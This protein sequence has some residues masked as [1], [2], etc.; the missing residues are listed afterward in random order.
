MAIFIK[1]KLIARD[2]VARYIE[3]LAA[4]SS[5]KS[6]VSSRFDID[7]PVAKIDRVTAQIQL[8]RTV[9]RDGFDRLYSVLRRATFGNDYYTY[10]STFTVDVYDLKVLL[11]ICAL[12][13]P[14]FTNYLHNCT[15]DSG[16]AGL[17][18]EIKVTD[19]LKFIGRRNDP[20]NRERLFTSLDR[21]CRVAVNAIIY[22]PTTA[23]L[24]SSQINCHENISGGLIKLFDR[25][26][27]TWFSIGL[28][29]TLAREA[30]VENDN[31]KYA[32]IAMRE[33]HALS[34]NDI[35]MILLV[36]FR[37]DLGAG[38]GAK[39]RYDDVVRLVRGEDGNLPRVYPRQ[40]VR[41]SRNQHNSGADRQSISNIK[42]A[43][44]IIDER[45]DMQ[46]YKHRDIS[47]FV[48]VRPATSASAV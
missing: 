3:D 41:N 20:E 39:Y 9:K 11:A 44:Q 32:P 21:L 12:G 31:P 42:I 28:L 16:W 26:G 4:F 30:W 18:C 37:S 17:A 6:A 46:I 23:R 2:K 33:V 40:G 24:G 10:R 1:G 19:M 47:W 38:S 15:G 22:N 45:T 34:K 36:F 27:D 7:N 35:A 8:F 48:V 25:A 5:K 43:L 14:P 29:W 13:K